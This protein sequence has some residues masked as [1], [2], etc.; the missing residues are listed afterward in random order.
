MGS[1]H[2]SAF[3]KCS[4]IRHVKS[5][6][7]FQFQSIERACEENKKA[8]SRVIETCNGEIAQH[9]NKIDIKFQ[10]IAGKRVPFYGPYLRQK[11][12]KQDIERY[13]VALKRYQR[14]LDRASGQYASF[15]RSQD[16]QVGGRTDPRQKAD[17]Q[18]HFLLSYDNHHPYFQDKNLP[19]QYARALAKAIEDSKC[20]QQMQA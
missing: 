4:R 13:P 1:I 6:C 15:A 9:I 7:L 17:V 8:D 14:R 11:L 5:I 18:M 20:R 12:Y 19:T 2:E 16:V 10:K 3:A